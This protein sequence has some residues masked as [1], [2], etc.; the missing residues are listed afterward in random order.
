MRAFMTGLILA[1]VVGLLVLPGVFSDTPEQPILFNHSAHTDLECSG[2]HD[3]VEEQTFAGFPGLDTCLLCHETPLTESPEEEKIRT[4]AAQGL[5][6]SWSRILRQPSHV[7]FSHRRHTAIGGLECSRCH[8]GMET[9]TAPP[10]ELDG[11]T[12]DEC[13]NCHEEN[14]VAAGCVDCHS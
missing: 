10:T 2:C 5:P 9:L 14:R 1:F 7:Y 6:L 8:E 13:I 4:M 11:L 12:M 3:G